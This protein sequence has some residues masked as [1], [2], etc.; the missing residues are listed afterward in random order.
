MLLLAVVIDVI[1]VKYCNGCVKQLL[2]I[3]VI[4]VTYCYGRYTLSTLFII[5]RWARGR[6]QVRYFTTI[7]IH[8]FFCKCFDY[9]K[10]KYKSK[11]LFAV[12]VECIFTL[13]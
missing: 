3:N 8:F 7:S 2:S 12:E 11:P 5:L 10:S 9:H 1:V 6:Y 4:V 13:L